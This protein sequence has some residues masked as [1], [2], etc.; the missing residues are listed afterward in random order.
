MYIYSRLQDNKSDGS[1]HVPISC[2]DALH[3]SRLSITSSYESCHVKNCIREANIE[4]Q[5]CTTYLYTLHAKK[6]LVFQ[7]R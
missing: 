2:S 4:V 1:L 5:A 6:V 7:L 3:R